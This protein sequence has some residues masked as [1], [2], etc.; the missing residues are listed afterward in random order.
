MHV[1]IPIDPKDCVALAQVRA[2]QAGVMQPLSRNDCASTAPSSVAACTNDTIKAKTAKVLT[3][4]A[5]DIVVER[6]RQLAALKNLG[7]RWE[8]LDE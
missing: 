4:L 1:H 7:S 2:E 8:K 6:D 3:L 5:T